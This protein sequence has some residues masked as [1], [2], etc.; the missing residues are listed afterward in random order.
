M[1]EAG[2]VNQLREINKTLAKL[3]TS[4]KILTNLID[5]ALQIVRNMKEDGENGDR[6]ITPG[7]DRESRPIGSED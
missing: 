3:S 2:I 7:T 6:S 5:Q 1:N 4:N